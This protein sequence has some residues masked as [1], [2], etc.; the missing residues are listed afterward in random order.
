MLLLTAATSQKW[1]DEESKQMR[2][3]AEGRDCN[4]E[5]HVLELP[6]TTTH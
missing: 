4:S 5:A 2:K 1:K 3:T 6:P